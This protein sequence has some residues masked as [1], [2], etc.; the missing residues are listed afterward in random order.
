MSLFELSF[1]VIIL[2]IFHC[3]ILMG[4]VSIGWFDFIIGYIM[5]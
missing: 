4:E 3:W 2:F 1:I 5:F